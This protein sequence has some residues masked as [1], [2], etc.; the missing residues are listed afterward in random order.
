MEPGESCA[1]AWESGTPL[2]GERA[3]AKPAHSYWGAAWRTGVV[4][5]QRR[6]A[7]AAR[8]SSAGG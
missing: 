8:V 7:V 4:R 6:F 2:R 1:F 3:R 5:A